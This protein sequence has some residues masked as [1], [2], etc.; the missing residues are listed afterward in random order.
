MKVIPRENWQNEFQYSHLH[1]PTLNSNGG[2][3]RFAISYILNII[4]LLNL[5]IVHETTKSSGPDVNNA[6]NRTA[7]WCERKIIV[8]S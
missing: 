1:L 6:V 3:A 5:N 2:W 4:G 7:L 8:I